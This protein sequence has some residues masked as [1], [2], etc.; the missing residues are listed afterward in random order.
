MSGEQTEPSNDKASRGVC[1]P[2][3]PVR[4]C[5]H[6]ATADPGDLV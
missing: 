1:S 4:P 2:V 6:V 5:E 3:R